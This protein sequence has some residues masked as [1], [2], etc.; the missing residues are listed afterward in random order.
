[1]HL[2]YP[3]AIYQTDIPMRNLDRELVHGNTETLVLALL[4]TD[5]GYGYAMRRQ[6]LLRSHHYFQLA[7][8]R[9]YPL[10][11]SLQQRGLAMARWVKVGKARERKHYTITARGRAELQ[12]RK[13][14]WRQFS[15]AMERVLSGRQS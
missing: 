1:M 4:A 12:E 10:L 2:I 5:E 7:F 13:R 11:R 15:D 8:G 9:L 3:L 14:K 6:L